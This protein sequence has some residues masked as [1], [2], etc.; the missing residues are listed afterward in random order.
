VLRDA[1]A[2][3]RP[4]RI[5]GCSS[6]LRPTSRGSLFQ[7]T[8]SGLPKALATVLRTCAKPS[9]DAANVLRDFF[10][11]ISSSNPN[12]NRLA[13]ASSAL[14]NLVGKLEVEGS[15]SDDDWQSVH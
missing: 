3:G 10:N 2:T 11:S 13:Q 1:K 9:K 6:L 7:R 5:A 4:K 8:S 15:A 14:Q 12:S